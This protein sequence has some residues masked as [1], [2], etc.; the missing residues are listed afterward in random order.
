MGQDATKILLG[1]TGSSFKNVDT[2]AA[3]IAAGLVCVLKSDNTLTNTLADG[4]MV[5]VSLGNDLSGTS[6]FTAVCR[7][8]SKVPLQVS[9]TPVIGAQVQIHAT[10][11]KGVDSGTAV[12]AVY[13]SLKLTAGGIQEDGTTVDIAYIEMVGGL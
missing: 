9:G 12:N 10:T 7:R 13:S 5:G 2:W 1:A 4:V 8:G 11:G 3:N 6:K